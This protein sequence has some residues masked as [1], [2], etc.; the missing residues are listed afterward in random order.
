MRFTEPTLWPAFTSRATIGG[1]LALASLNLA[2]RDQVP[3]FPQRSPPSFLTTAACGGLRSAPD[4]RPRRALLHLPYSCALPC[5]LA[6][7][8]TQD[9]R[10]K[11]RSASE[12]CS[13][14]PDQCSLPPLTGSSYALIM[15]CRS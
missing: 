14:L 8:V 13:I 6:M 15:S 1:L 4:C 7:L 3:T 2:C 9:P 12:C 11:S 10:Q 5:G